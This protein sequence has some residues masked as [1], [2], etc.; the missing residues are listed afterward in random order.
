MTSYPLNCDRMYVGVGAGVLH[1]AGLSQWHACHPGAPGFGVWWGLRTSQPALHPVQ[2]ADTPCKTEADS[3]QLEL[4]A[5]ERKS[6]WRS[7]QSAAKPT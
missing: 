1:R 4:K 2:A 7:Q 6:Q 5:C 3:W